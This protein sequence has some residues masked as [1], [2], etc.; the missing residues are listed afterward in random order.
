VQDCDPELSDE[1][2]A[3]CDWYFICYARYRG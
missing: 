3:R 2:V 1:K